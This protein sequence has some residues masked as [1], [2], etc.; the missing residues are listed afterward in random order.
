MFSVIDSD[1]DI[2]VYT[3]LTAAP[4]VYASSKTTKSNPA[5]VSWVEKTTGKDSG[6]AKYVLVDMS[7]DADAK[8]DD[9]S[10]D[11]YLFVLHDSNKAHQHR[12][13]QGLLRV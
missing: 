1:D 13:R 7:D 11:D 2:D 12:Q 9:A 10:S 5:Y 6:Y 8:I 4:D 3:G